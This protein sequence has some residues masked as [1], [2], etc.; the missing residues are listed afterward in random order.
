MR[1]TGGLGEPDGPMASAKSI[2]NHPLVMCM[3]SCIWALYLY[4]ASNSYGPAQAVMTGY[5][6]FAYRCSQARMAS[7]LTRTALHRPVQFPH[8][9]LNGCLGPCDSVPKTHREPGP[10]R[11]CTIIVNFFTGRMG[12]MR[13]H[14]G[15]VRP[16]LGP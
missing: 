9:Y 2:Q 4:G 10:Q 7:T 5:A 6:Q 13:A 1:P 11:A 15:L 8:V 16:V 14:T 3:V 12:P